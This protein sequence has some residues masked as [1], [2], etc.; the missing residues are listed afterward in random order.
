MIKPFHLDFI[1]STNEELASQIDIVLADCEKEI[2]NEVGERHQYFLDLKEA[3]IK[4]RSCLYA[5]DKIAALYQ[6]R[7]FLNNHDLF[8]NKS[9]M[10]LSI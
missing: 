9:Y 10:P 1:H 4:A 7:N 2:P 5:E 8:S 3:L 6:C